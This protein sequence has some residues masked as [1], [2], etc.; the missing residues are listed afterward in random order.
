MSS[1]YKTIKIAF[2]TDRSGHSI[3][4]TVGNP[5]RDRDDGEGEGDD[6]FR[7]TIDEGAIT[8]EDD[9]QTVITLT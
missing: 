7:P 8:E 5:Q 1:W 3:P 9:I 2:S 4:E 6:E